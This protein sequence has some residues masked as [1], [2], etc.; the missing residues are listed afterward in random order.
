SDPFDI[1]ETFFG[2]ASPFRR[3]PAK[4]LYQIQIDFMDA[5]NG[6]SKSF[7]HQGKQYTV[8]IPAGAD[9]G[10]RIRYND[11]DISLK[12]APHK[13]FHREG[14]DVI[15]DHEIPFPLAALGGDVV[16]ETLD[17]SLKL[18]VKAGTQPGNLVRLTGKGVHQ[19][20]GNRRGDF[21]IRYI[22]KVPTKLSREQKELLKKLENSF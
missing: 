15:V 6:T 2:G 18:K 12:V 19:I 3:A 14:S 17:G 10:T 9:N 8:K 5:V 11:F 21:Y 16:V 13:H 4:P 1:F 20:N 22:I 7:V